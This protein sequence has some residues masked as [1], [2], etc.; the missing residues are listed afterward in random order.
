MSKKHL[1]FLLMTLATLALGSILLAACARPGAPT[2]TSTGGGGGPSS[3]GTPTAG[4]SSGGEPS[5]HMGPA[6]FIQSTVD[7][8]KGSKLMLIDDGQFLHI[9][10]NGTWANST[11][12]PAKEAGAPT[13]SNVMVN[14]S[15]LE[16]GPFT[17]AGTFNIYCSVHANMNLTITVK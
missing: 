12:K 15:T 14:G 13:V 10:A 16:I 3:G 17:T 7:V 9:I 8:P 11:P 2:T 5:V 1:S 6:T 4:T